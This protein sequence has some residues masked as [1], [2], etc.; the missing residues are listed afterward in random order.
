[1][2][3]KDLENVAGVEYRVEIADN[4]DELTLGKKTGEKGWNTMLRAIMAKD[5]WQG[6]LDEPTPIRIDIFVD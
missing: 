2:T 6:N 4:L 3:E 5:V 1:M